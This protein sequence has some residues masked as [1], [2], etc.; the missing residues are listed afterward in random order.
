MQVSVP[1]P[2]LIAAFNNL[3]I[4]DDAHPSAGNL[5][6]DGSSYSAQ[7]LAAVGLSQGATVT[8]DGLTFTWPNASPGTTNNVAAGGQTIA[9]SGSGS[10]L[11]FLGCLRH[12]YDHLHRRHHQAFTLGFADWYANAAVSGDILATVPYI[13]TSKGNKKQRV[14]TYYASA[15]LQSGKTVQYVTLPDISQGVSSGQTSMHVFAVAIG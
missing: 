15:S 8:H 13:N 5:D 14:S 12:R 7:S 6:G 3:G 4:S 9:L 10:T 11:G 1:Y 2:S